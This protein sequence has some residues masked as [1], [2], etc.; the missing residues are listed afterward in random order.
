M[1]KYLIKTQY[2]LFEIPIDENEKC[3][4]FTTKKLPWKQH[5]FHENV[6]NKFEPKLKLKLSEEKENRL[7]KKG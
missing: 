3:P 7:E 5:E 2:V 4:S 1:K 6:V